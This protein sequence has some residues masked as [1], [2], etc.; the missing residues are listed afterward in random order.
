M[1]WTRSEITKAAIEELTLQKARVRQVHNVPIRRRQNHVQKGW[2]DIQ[3]YSKE[4]IAVL[5]EV[6]TENDTFY[7]EQIERLTDASKCGCMCF[8][9]TVNKNGYFELKQFKY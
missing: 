6:K 8:I 5:V 2:P 4:G 3:G 7:P 1:S 9:A